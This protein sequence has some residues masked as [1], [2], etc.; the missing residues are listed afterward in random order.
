M[1]ETITNWKHIESEEREREKIEL[2]TRY[3]LQRE[4]KYVYVYASENRDEKVSK[5][6]L[7][8][9]S[10]FS[11]SGSYFETKSGAT[12]FQHFFHCCFSFT[13]F[14]AFFATECE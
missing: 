1:A 4:R 8:I 12:L 14:F 7:T 2:S 10:S 5:Q 13:F 9:L 11:A 6:I 3:L